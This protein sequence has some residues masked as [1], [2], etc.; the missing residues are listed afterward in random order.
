[1]SSARATAAI[2]PTGGS[3]LL[4]RF[5]C[6]LA[7]SVAVLLYLLMA[8]GNARADD[9]TLAVESAASGALRAALESGQAPLSTPAPAP[10]PGAPAAAAGQQAAT[11]Q[12]AGADASVDQ[13]QPK[14]IVVSI[15]INSPGNDGPINQS[16]VA[17][18]EASASNGAASNQGAAGG[19]G[20]PGDQQASTDQAAGSS[21][22]VEQDD[23]GNL[24]ISIRINSPGNNGAV[25]QG[26]TTIAISNSGN[27][28]ITNQG[29]GGA[30]SP[31]TAPAPPR[32][33][34]P[35]AH[36]DRQ[37]ASAN[38]VRPRARRS[39]PP[40]GSPPGG[41]HRATT[42]ARTPPQASQTPSQAPSHAQLRATSSEPQTAASVASQRA[43]PKH[44]RAETSKPRHHGAIARLA[45]QSVAAVPNQAADLLG[46]LPRPSVQAGQSSEDA[47]TA[48]MLT[49]I[50]V[51]GAFAVLLGSRFLPTA[52][53]LR[54][55]WHG[56]HG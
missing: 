37:W 5:V 35:A 26:N 31:S 48:V 25:N 1:M 10:A 52:T 12:V 8:A 30:A 11:G 18:G 23:A 13:Q 4:S 50:A 46:R 3:P 33:A 32:T 20:V 42:A 40:G 17:A 34:I 44:S 36:G 39:S 14:N 24:V 41:S 27:V 16:N 19:G 22:V 49:L 28:S 56:R 55:P 45:G 43:Q 6:S 2:R 7:L 21:A 53:R 15:R 51:L 38:G 47:S 54:A 9:G 29:M